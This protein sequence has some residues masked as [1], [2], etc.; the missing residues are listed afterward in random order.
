MKKALCI[1]IFLSQFVWANDNN[2]AFAAANK[3]YQA[4][5]YNLAVQYYNLASKGNQL[6]SA[7]LY[8]NLG[9]CYYKLHKVALAI[10]NYEKAK[11]L[12]QLD[13]EIETNLEFAR[14][15]TIDDIKVIPKVGFGKIIQDFTSTYHFDTWAWI[16]VFQSIMVFIFFIGY[17][18]A[19]TSINKRMF[20]T[21]LLI[22]I[23]GIFISLF[24]AYFEK[25]RLNSENPAI[26]F[27]DK[28][29][30]K[31]EPKKSSQD[32]FILHEGTKVFILDNVAN[33]SKIQ[34]SDETIGWIEQNAIRS[35]RE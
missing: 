16:A 1:L 27:A 12:D 22:L 5:K 28:V 31:S 6:E 9:N 4:G 13:V 19:N 35:L 29:I 2:K 30:V 11:Q 10:Y 14:K 15:M 17:Y 32:A 21:A 23:F 33:W 7:E 3:Y 24:S 8:F 34:L 20:F 18:Y 25:N 26:V